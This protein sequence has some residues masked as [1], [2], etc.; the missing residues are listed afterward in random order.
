MFIKNK[1]QTIYY[2]GFSMKP[3]EGVKLLENKGEFLKTLIEEFQ[4]L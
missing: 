3:P 2:S 1:K 4:I